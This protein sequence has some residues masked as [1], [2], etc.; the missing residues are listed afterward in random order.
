VIEDEDE[1]QH[2][3]NHDVSE[4]SPPCNTEECRLR[5]ILN[6]TKQRNINE[7]EQSGRYDERHRWAERHLVGQ[8]RREIDAADNDKGHRYY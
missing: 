2:P 8:V 1:F 5:K 3:R 6:S 7:Q 4:Q